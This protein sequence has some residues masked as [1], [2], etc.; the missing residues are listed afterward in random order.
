MAFYALR[1]VCQSCGSAFLV[2]GSTAS[3]LA[4]WRSL[5]VECRNCLAE[6]PALG[7]ETVDLR[8]A[9]GVAGTARAA[10]VPHA[11]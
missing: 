3:D 1:V 6:T 2:G 8:P 10:S 5:T 9:P 11:H 4:Q 7:G